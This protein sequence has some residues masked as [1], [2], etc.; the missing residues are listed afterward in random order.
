MGGWH[1]SRDTL[2][3]ITTAGFQITSLQQ[4]RFP[5]GVTALRAYRGRIPPLTGTITVDAPSTRPST[6]SP[7]ASPA[8]GRF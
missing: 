6:A 4:F 5:D 1:T 7:T 3:A 2:A 8:G